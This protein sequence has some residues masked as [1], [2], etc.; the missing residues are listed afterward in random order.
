MSDPLRQFYLMA[1]GTLIEDDKMWNH[2]YDC[3]S[4]TLYRRYLQNTFPLAEKGLV[5][6]NRLLKEQSIRSNPN[7]P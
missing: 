5:V 7:R 3:S 1:Y 4:S 6:I 2:E